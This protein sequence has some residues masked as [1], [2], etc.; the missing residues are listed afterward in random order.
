MTRT[1][2][3]LALAFVLAGAVAAC[4]DRRDDDDLDN[5]TPADRTR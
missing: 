1:V 2:L 3:T 5:T 4:A